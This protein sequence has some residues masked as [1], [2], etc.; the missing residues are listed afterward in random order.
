MRLP[1]L[2]RNWFSQHAKASAEQPA[3]AQVPAEPAPPLDASY[4]ADQPIGSIKE[5][6][7]NRAPFAQRIAETLARRSD[8][9]S[10]VVGVYGVWGD[11]KTSTLRMMEET[12]HSYPNVIAVRFNP[13]NFESEELLLRAFFDTLAEALGKS[14]PTRKEELGRVLQRYGSLLSIASVGLAAGAVQVNLG[15]AVQGVGQALSTV[16][17]DELRV[18]LERILRDARKRVVVLIDDIDRLDR[19]EIQAIFKLVKLSASF[20]HMSYVLAFDDEMVA[21]AIGEKYGS[22]DP[23]AGRSFLEKIVQVPLHL[24]PADTLA[25]RQMT[26]EGVDAITRQS[27][28]KL[29]EQQEQE[30]VR[31]FVDGF[32]ARLTTPRQSKLYLN[33]L[34]FALPILRGEV[35]PVDQMLVEGLRV[36][37][38][39][40]YSVM[41]DNPEYFLKGLRG[42]GRQDE[43]YRKHV[44]GIING[45]LDGMGVQDKKAIKDGL[46]EPL[47]PRLK[48]IFGNTSYGSDWETRWEREQ[49]VCSEAYFAR[50]FS[51]AVPPGDVPDLKIVQLLE[52]LASASEESVNL[53]I[54]EL[55]SGVG[56]RRL[57]SKLRRRESDVAQTLCRPLALAVVRN[58]HVI[59]RDEGPMME[60]WTFRQAG[61]LVAHL[62]KRLPAGEPRETLA[63]EIIEKADP[64]GFAFECLRWLRTDTDEPE[65]ERILPLEVE[66]QMA[67]QLLQRVQVEASKEPLYRKF[68]R[69][70]PRLL[71]LWSKHGP[72]GE[73]AKHLQDQLEADPAGIDQLLDAYV[74]TAWGMESGLPHKSDLDRGNYDAIAKI[75][76]P[77]IVIDKLKR[78]Y[79]SEL[80]DSAYHFADDVPIPLRIANQFAHI[81]KAIEQEKAKPGEPTEEGGATSV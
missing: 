34:M 55:G 11:G 36:F 56:S 64:L 72:P 75:I 57:I 62:V 81:H 1:R 23:A 30:F 77:E 65:S 41:R 58:G 28:L 7:F 66:T 40:L 17:L 2:I 60:D 29:S 44:V 43:E 52:R 14:L 4:A 19:K 20:E 9:S 73:V 49:R 59:I 15:D 13:W 22:G 53:Q 76:S 27:G 67:E 68:R 69:D 25:L 80:Q 74:G 26:F 24:P 47:F 37:Y 8:V 51:Y 78:R 54:Q 70:A 39:K 16:E 6:R 33:S 42:G 31:H 12:L 35:N 3:I 63:K 61:I 45:A 18:R 71:W 79:K 38:P 46:L 10:V 5:D 48:S 32:E 50:Y 21:A